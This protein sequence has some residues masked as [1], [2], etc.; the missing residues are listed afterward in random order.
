MHERELLHR[1]AVMY[2]VHGET[3]EAISAQLRTSR[4]SVSRLLKEA[5]TSGLVQIKVP[6]LD[7]VAS[8]LAKTLGQHFGIRVHLVP[9]RKKATP[10]QRLDQTARVAA[11]LVAG[12]FDDDQVLGIAWGT[13]LSA[14]AV[15]LPTHRVRNAMIVQL[16]G[17]ENNQPLG[18]AHASELLRQFGN[19]FDAT[20]THFPTPAFFDHAETKAAMWRESSIQR[21]LSLQHRCDMAL[22]GVGVVS[23]QLRSKVH[24]GGYLGPAEYRELREERVAGDICTVFLRQ[25]GSWEDIDLNRRATG[26]TP[27][28]LARI[29]RRVCVAAGEDKVPGLLAALRSGAVTDLVIDH[30]TA[31]YLNELVQPAQ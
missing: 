1:V 17:A 5:R 29:P 4:S 16:N 11:Q 2:Y 31:R 22:F 21:V 20:V 25:D 27:K 18:V 23:A 9:V 30:E 19:A 14:I 3:M 8:P 6:E 26:P 13:T 24:S 12:W 10:L 28:D 7:P 15:H